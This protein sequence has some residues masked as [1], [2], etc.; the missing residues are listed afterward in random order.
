MNKKTIF[1]DIDGTL[2]GTK[3]GK[4]FCI[5]QSALEALH[6]LKERGHRIAICSGRQELFIHKFFPN[7]FTSYVAMNGTHVVFDGKTILDLPFSAEKVAELM[8]HFDSYGCSY[9]F[10]G[11][12]HGWG[13]NLPEN[14]IEKLNFLYGLPDFLSADWEPGDVEANMMDFIFPNE[15]EFERCR[16]AF[17]GSM[18]LNR[19]PGQLAS[20]LSFKEYDKAK[21]IEA[22]LDYAGIDKSDTVAFGDG[23]NDV[24]MM[25]A[26]GCGIAMGNAVDQVKEAADYVTTDVFDDGIYNALKHF[27]LI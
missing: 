18:V 21:G 9:T 23:Y 27:E 17:S 22:F 16:P 5:P 10:V 24:T 1:F 7:L 13:R 14:H 4:Y 11:K 2:L 25:G 26:V 15:E 8:A 3:N 12:S 20:D 6:A 19:H